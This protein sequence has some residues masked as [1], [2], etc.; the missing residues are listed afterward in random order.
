MSEGR[1][2]VGKATASKDFLPQQQRIVVL[3]QQRR[4]SLGW[5]ERQLS[6]EAGLHR[7]SMRRVLECTHHVGLGDF[8]ALC[9]ALRL[10]PATVLTTTE[11]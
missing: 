1:G 5:S 3:F 4:A 6:F 11:G 9:K 10:N 8:Y 2:F 7:S